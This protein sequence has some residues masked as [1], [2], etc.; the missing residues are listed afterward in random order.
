MAVL[1]GALGAATQLPE[2]QNSVT[3]KI[4]TKAEAD[5]HLRLSVERMP[6]E[7]CVGWLTLL[8]SPRRSREY[9]PGKNWTCFW[10]SGPLFH[11]DANEARTGHNTYGG[12]E[13][14]PIPN[15][16]LSRHLPPLPIHVRPC[17]NARF[18]PERRPGDDRPSHKGANLVPLAKNVKICVGAKGGSPII[19]GVCGRR[20]QIS[21]NPAPPR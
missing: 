21:L 20:T 9:H 19:F 4:T 13:M 8:P 18:V 10:P 2:R 15:Y 12:P 7:C 14:I 6:N 17:L 11:R 16:L 1:P 5:L 3:R